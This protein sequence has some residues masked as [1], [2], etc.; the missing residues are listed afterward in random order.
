M[1][2]R[3]WWKRAV[4]YEVCVPTFSDGTLRGVR[5]RLDHL[6]WL[7]VDALWL[8]PF[9]PSEMTDFG[10]D[11]IDHAA[12]HPKAGTLEDFDQ[13]IADAHARG[14]RVILDLVPNHTSD[15]S[16]WFQESASSRTSEKRS[17]YVWAEPAPDGGP[18]N[19]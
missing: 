10:Y 9:Y 1:S 7:G 19:N 6:T 15:R 8:T 13:L 17:W 14:M 11:I 5:Q 2:D 12:V 18:P 16:P 3:D 4:I